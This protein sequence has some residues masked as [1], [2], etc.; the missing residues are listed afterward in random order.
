VVVAGIG[1]EVCGR[2]I[3]VDPTDYN[4][5]EISL[6]VQCQVTVK[7]KLDVKLHTSKLWLKS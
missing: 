1:F 3:G 7:C 2:G 5:W 4:H 6:A